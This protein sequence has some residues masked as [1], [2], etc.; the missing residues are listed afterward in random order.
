MTIPPHDSLPDPFENL[1]PL[2]TP[3]EGAE[4]ENPRSGSARDR[5]ARRKGQQMVQPS[6]ARKAPRQT[7]PAGRVQM[8][9]FRLPFNRL[10]LTIIGG[11]LLVLLVVFALGQLRPSRVQVGQHG[12]WAGTE[13]TYETPDDEAVKAFAEQLKEHEI[14][15]V[16]AWVS[17]LQ[18]DGSWRGTT[19][20]P[21]V[22]TFVDQFRAAYPEATL[23]GWISLPVQGGADGYRLDDEGVQDAIAEFSQR[24]V[25]DFGF[26][27]VFLNVEPVWDG[28][29]NFLSL[30]RKVRAAVGINTL[31]S[32]ATPPDW[33][34]LN[35]TIPVPPLIEPG[36]EWST[37]FKQSVALLS[38]E[39]AVMAYVSGLSSPD[40][41][42]QWVAYQ[43]VTFASAIA[44]LGEG[45][46]IMIGIPTFDAE[47]PGHDP[48]VE[49]IASAH[50][51]FVLGLKN[52]G[53][54][55]EFVRGMAIYAGWTTDAQE[56]A[57]FK[58]AVSSS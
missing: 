50:A 1:P 51:G 43:V 14:G 20:F 40:D 17:W 6:A 29:E 57:A 15:T 49:N 42:S 48:L 23:Y 55:A 41:Y 21:N 16:Y 19:N 36:T 7:A 27:G 12:I 22:K 58:A 45:T 52:A 4:S 37:T 24:V 46:H 56:W 44:P 31:I 10:W 54:A 35:P 26:D 28:D 34:P 25:N 5:Q 9:R 11:I 33:S 47:P 3:P 38:D 39:L 30:L 18:E 8:P 13:W 32:V 2:A 53:A